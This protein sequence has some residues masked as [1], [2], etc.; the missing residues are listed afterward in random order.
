MQH[1]DARFIEEFKATEEPN[2]GHAGIGASAFKKPAGLITQVKHIYTNSQRMA[3]KH[4]ELE[5]I[6]QQENHYTVAVPEMQWKSCTAGV[7]QWMTVNCSE[8]AGK[9]REV[10]G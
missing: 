10:V 3:H 1:K 8:R 9:E 6:A 4:E 7:L 2:N 5:A